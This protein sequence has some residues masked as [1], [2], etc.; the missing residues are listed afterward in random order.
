MGLH[1][2]G[3]VGK[4][5]LEFDTIQAQQDPSIAESNRSDC[6]RELTRLTW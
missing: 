1:L 6:D 4:V 5:G 2:A 3:V